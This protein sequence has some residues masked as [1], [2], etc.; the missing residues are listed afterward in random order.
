MRSETFAKSEF[1]VESKFD[2]EELE[3]SWAQEKGFVDEGMR[4]KVMVW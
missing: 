3:G 2:G 4:V 1:E